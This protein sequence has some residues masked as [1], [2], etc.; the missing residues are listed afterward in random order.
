MKRVLFSFVTVVLIFVIGEV[1]LRV[2][3]YGGEYP[4]FIKTELGGK[5]KWQ[6]NRE[7][8]RRYFNLKDDVIPEASEELFDVERKEK[9]LRVICLGGSTTAGF[10]YEVNATFPFQLQYRLRNALL[11]HY[12]EV[13]NLG[14][15]AVNSFTVRDLMP[16]VLQADPDVIVVYMGHNEFYGA[17]GAA[18][19]ISFTQN[20]SLVRAHFALKGYRVYQLLNDVIRG[21]GGLFADTETNASLMQ[22][23]AEDRTIEKNDAVFRAGV[24]NFEENLS[25]IVEMARADTVTVILSTLVSNLAD[26][27]PFV[28]ADFSAPAV[29]EKYLRAL[30]LRE[31]GNTDEAL[32]LLREVTQNDSTVADAHFEMGKTLLMKDDSLAAREAFVR[33]REHDMLRFRAPEAINARIAFLAEK[34]NVPLADMGVVFEAASP[35]GIPGGTLFHEHLHPNFDGYRLMAQTFF[36]VMRRLQVLNP[37]KPIAYE[38]RLLKQSNINDIL[39][40]YRKTRGSVTDLDLEFGHLRA[41]LL[42]NRWPF[43]SGGDAF[44]IKPSNTVDPQTANLAYRHLKNE[45]SWSEAHYNLAEYYASQK[46]YKRA[47]DELRAV[48]LAFYDNYIPHMKLGD[49][50]ALQEDFREAPRWYKNA[51][52][53]DPSNANLMVKLGQSYVFARQFDN[54]VKYLALA[55]SRDMKTGEF[56]DFQKANV[57]YL[58]AVS[59]ANLKRFE[60]ANREI[61]KALALEPTLTQAQNLRQKIETYREEQENPQ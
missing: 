29:R 5:E 17:Y 47:F 59:Y 41:Q 2:A 35:E 49:L 27:R 57:H 11:D 45:I 43:K 16:E 28:S 32:Q 50:A 6:V 44:E 39:N 3:G 42:T 40:G 13:V 55:L 48:N 19:S 23:L 33:A 36:E 22:R 30:S 60:D 51:L 31:N 1:L 12:V 46:Q 9:S 38:P 7:V 24:R 4:L 37:P 8:T 15:S 20:P 54:A 10:P 58:Q 52:E 21:A 25:A 34:H 14:I 18:S 56:S 61:D 26:Q 53:R